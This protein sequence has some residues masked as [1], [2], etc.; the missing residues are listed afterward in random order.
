MKLMYQENGNFVSKFWIIRN[1]ISDQGSQ[2]VSWPD[3]HFHED[4]KSSFMWSS[5]DD[6]NSAVITVQERKI[7]P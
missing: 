2:E 7:I 5:S 6:V 4:L 1:W 3:P